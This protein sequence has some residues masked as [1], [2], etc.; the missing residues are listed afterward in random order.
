MVWSALDRKNP[1]KGVFLFHGILFRRNA[2]DG[3]VKTGGKHGLK[4]FQVPANEK[5]RHAEVAVGFGTSALSVFRFFLGFHAVTR[6]FDDEGFII[7]D[8]SISTAEA[9]VLS[10]VKM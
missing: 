3:G 7:M 6:A 5:N 8:E 9:M 2:V 10:L 1:S 4:A